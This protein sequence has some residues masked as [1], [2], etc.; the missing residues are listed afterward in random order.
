M[1]TILVIDDEPAMRDVIRLALESVHY[2]VIEAP[3]GDLGVDLFR[4]HRPFLVITDFFLPGKPGIDVIREL[5]KV[6]PMARIIAISGIGSVDSVEFPDYAQQLG[7]A[8]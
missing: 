3:D 1:Q 5:Q 6:D 2:R 4:E 7:L 8:A